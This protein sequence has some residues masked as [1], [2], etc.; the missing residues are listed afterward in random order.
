VID[1]MRTAPRAAVATCLAL[2]P[3]LVQ[4]A[5]ASD[6]QRQPMATTGP[7]Q[8]QVEQALRD[9]AQ[10]T[11]LDR[12]R[13][14]V[15]L[16]EAVTWPDGALGCPEPGRQYT[17][18]LVSGYRIHIDAGSRLLQYHGS[19]KGQPFLCPAERVQPPSALG[20]AT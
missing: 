9:A 15:A 17:Q 12:A 8:T 7:F 16:A 20:P 1:T 19:L 14:R 4:C 5:A 18:A 6:A 10:R 11:Q 3:F 13:L 2:A